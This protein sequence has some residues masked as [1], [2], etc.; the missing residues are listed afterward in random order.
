MIRK[1]ILLTLFI[2]LAYPALSCQCMPQP[3]EKDHTRYD[4]IFAGKLIDIDVDKD[5]YS[6]ILIKSWKGN[7][8]SDTLIKRTMRKLK[9]HRL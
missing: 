8:S 7:F 4:Y 1:N 9:R 5:V 6:L 3:I 2:A